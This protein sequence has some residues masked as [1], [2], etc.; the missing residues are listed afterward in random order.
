MKSGEGAKPANRAKTLW[1][2][3]PYLSQILAGRKTVEVEILKEA[4]DKSR[5]KKL[6]WLAQSLP[7]GGSR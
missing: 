4:L 2:R 1:I 3:E 5:S 6:T 7:K